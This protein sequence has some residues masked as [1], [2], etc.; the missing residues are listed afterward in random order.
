MVYLQPP[1]ATRR[2]KK[3]TSD[4]YLSLLKLFETSKNIIFLFETQKESE[5]PSTGSTLQMPEC[6]EWLRDVWA[7]GTQPSEPSPDSLWV[8]H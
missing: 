7:A 6:P 1:E 3:H 8:I 2:K 5:L 4:G